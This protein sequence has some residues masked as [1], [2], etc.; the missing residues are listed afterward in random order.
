MY[1]TASSQLASGGSVTNSGGVYYHK[2]T[3]G[4]TFSI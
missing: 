4:G 3:S 2:F 1:Y